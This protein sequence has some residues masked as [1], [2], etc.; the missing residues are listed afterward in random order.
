MKIVV[1]GAS[2]NAGGRIAALLA[3]GL[4][5]DD[6]LVLAGRSQRKLAAARVAVQGPAHVL[7]APADVQDLPGIQ[8]LVTGSDLVVVAVSRPD[9]VGDLARIVL[10]A[11]ADW[12]DTMLSSPTKLA[13]LRTLEPEIEAA[14]RCF[15]TDCGFHPGLPAVLVRWAGGQLDDLVEA[16]VMAGLRIDWRTETLA[17]S[18]VEEMLTELADFDLTTWIDGSRR[19][20]SWRECPTIDFGEPIGRKAVVPMALAEMDDLPRQFTSLRRCGFYVCGF[21]PPMD[22]AV[23]P[24]LMA[25]AKVRALRGPA[26]ALTRWSMRHLASPRPP[27]RLVVQLDATGQLDGS[28]ATA[29]VSVAGTDA[30]L[31]TA[32]PVVACL[33]RVL[34]GSDRRVGLHLQ[35][36]LV[37]PEPFLAELARFG[38]AVNTRVEKG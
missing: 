32:A 29:S 17:E 12:C 2:G 25:M 8:Q 3:P 30:Y 27:H 10:D 9:L 13:A 31:L 16:D 6:E 5:A 20:L 11:G 35:G 7:L 19:S 1:L 28:P 18:T 37:A 26:V 34:D 33:R 4:S 15:V 38:L 36:Q 21:S 24:L 14:G 23:L 22:Y